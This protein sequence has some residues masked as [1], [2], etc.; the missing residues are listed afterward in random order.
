MV[1]V[2]SFCGMGASFPPLPLGACWDGRSPRPR[3]RGDNAARSPE[4]GA[5]RSLGHENAPGSAVRKGG[6]QSAGAFMGSAAEHQGVTVA[7]EAARCKPVVARAGSIPVA[8]YPGIQVSRYPVIGLLVL[9]PR[10]LLFWWHRGYKTPS[11]KL[12]LGGSG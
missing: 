4:T 1:A 9:Y 11:P 6:L 5:G 3:H 8:T 10:L 2:G 7:G 12:S